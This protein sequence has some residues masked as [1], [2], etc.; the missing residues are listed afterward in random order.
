[1]FI[2]KFIYL[3]GILA[4]DLFCVKVRVIMRLKSARSEI[5]SLRMLQAREFACTLLFCPEHG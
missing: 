1:L 3:F 2:K 5:H 4:L